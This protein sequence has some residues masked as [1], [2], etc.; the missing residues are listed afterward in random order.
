MGGCSGSSLKS[1]P[2]GT[3]AGMQTVTVTATSAGVSKTATVTLTVK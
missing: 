3:P 2:N 1:N